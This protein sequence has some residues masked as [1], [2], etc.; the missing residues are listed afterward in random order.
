MTF[1]TGS[2][3][4]NQFLT[5]TTAR[6]T[7][8]SS[9]SLGGGSEATNLLANACDRASLV[10]LADQLRSDDPLRRGEALHLIAASSQTSLEIASRLDDSDLS[11]LQAHTSRLREIDAGR[12]LQGLKL[13]FLG[14]IH[15]GWGPVRK[16]V[17]HECRTGN[18]VVL[19]VGDL[20]TYKSINAKVPFLFS[21]GNHEDEKELA[22]LRK[23][24]EL[25]LPYPL[26]A[27]DYALIRGG[28]ALG[29][30]SGIYDG[31]GAYE[32]GESGV[33]PFFSQED[34]V[35]TLGI[36]LSLDIFL[37][38]EAPAGIGLL[39]GERD[40][41]SRVVAEVLEKLQPKVAF[42][43]H[44]H[45]ENFDGWLGRTRVIGLDYPK[46]SY[47][48]ATV[49]GAGQLVFKRHRA[50]EIEKDGGKV[51]RY[52]W[53]TVEGER[54]EGVRRLFS[55]EMP[56]LMEREGEIEK[57]LDGR[58]RA[59]L[60]E[61]LAPILLLRVGNES[62]TPRTKTL[63]AEGLANG[64]FN[65]ILPYF[66]AYYASLKASL[67]SKEKDLLRQAALKR[68]LAEKSRI[69]YAHD[70]LTLA[71]KELSDLVDRA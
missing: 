15:D 39:R 26:Y 7:F 36:P 13:L 57:M 46:L 49:D 5:A 58:Y 32:K 51:Y 20:E 41:G 28:L 12:G 21:H 52:D 66:A 47:V 34:V 2:Y 33:F 24:P 45:R 35:K 67:S 1:T 59:A 8:L 64:L 6:S 4:L 9:L 68:M 54:E 29:A 42:F 55:M 70:D 23:N 16:I 61:K 25:G 50:K 43:G 48:T 53:E 60:A 31:Q 22:R 71:F 69:P 17:N 63:L 27:G 11:L 18:E 40:L 56:T 44:H 10:S 37:A 30:F 62:D 14:D 19:G 38:H 65:T 3:S